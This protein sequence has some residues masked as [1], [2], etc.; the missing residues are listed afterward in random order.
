MS[1][2]TFEFSNGKICGS[3]DVDSTAA[4]ILP[5]DNG[6]PR[7]GP[8]VLGPFG[9]DKIQVELSERFVFIYAA[10]RLR[11]NTIYIH[12]NQFLYLDSQGIGI[13]HRNIQLIDSRGPVPNF[14]RATAK[15]WS[16]NLRVLNGG[17]IVEADLLLTKGVNITFK[18]DFS[19]PRVAY[20]PE[21]PKIFREMPFLSH[22]VACRNNTDPG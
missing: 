17:N 13:R 15:K 9:S 11:N 10:K 6:V 19:N 8:L 3:V 4:Q 2:S 7:P 16:P 1:H 12:R 20:A 22:V 18:F 21:Q 14:W 5:V